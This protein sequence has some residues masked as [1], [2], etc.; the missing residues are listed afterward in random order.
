LLSHSTCTA[1]P[2]QEKFLEQAKAAGGPQRVGEG[3]TGAS[4]TRYRPRARVRNST[5]TGVRPLRSSDGPRGDGGGGNRHTRSDP[6]Y[7]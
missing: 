1:T 6:S 5:P 2:G 7:Q 3:M 4:G